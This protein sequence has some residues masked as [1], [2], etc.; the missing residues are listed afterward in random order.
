MFRHQF[1]S[2]RLAAALAVVG[3][4]A[5]LGCAAALAHGGPTSGENP[6]QPVDQPALGLVYQGLE[7]ATTGPCAGSYRIGSTDHCTHGPDPVSDDPAGDAAIA[8]R[9]FIPFPSDD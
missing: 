1:R 6:L 8:A 5:A 9:S 4:I 7:F 3:A 2:G